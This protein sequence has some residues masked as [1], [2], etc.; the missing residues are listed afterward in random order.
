MQVVQ[1]IGGQEDPE[2][3]EAGPEKGA[4][5]VGFGFHEH[6]GGGSTTK[7]LTPKWIIDELG[8]FDSDPC[9]APAPRPWETAKKYGVFEGLCFMNPPYGNEIAAW[10]KRFQKHKNGI[11]LVFA[12]TDT[13]WFQQ[14][15]VDASIFLFMDGRITFCKPDGTPGHTNSGAPSVFVGYG[16]EAASR[17]IHCGIHGKRLRGI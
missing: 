15:T 4:H 5:G 16:S 8:E 13:R 17:L 12:R 6:S 9:P 2:N 1:G 14:F 3:G 7:W 11:A 10:M